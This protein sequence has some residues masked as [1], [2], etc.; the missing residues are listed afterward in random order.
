[1]PDEPD[2][3]LADLLGLRTA[4]RSELQRAQA[5]C[6]REPDGRRALRD[7]FDPSAHRQI[8][9]SLDDGI[10]QLEPR[11]RKRRGAARDYVRGVLAVVRLHLR[12]R[13]NGWTEARIAAALARHLREQDADGELLAEAAL[14]WKLS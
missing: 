2:I 11:V 7:I 8:N 12:L 14:G 13:E 9:A 4:F 1:M 6:P 3:E 10:R 5:Q